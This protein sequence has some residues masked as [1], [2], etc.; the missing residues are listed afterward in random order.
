MEAMNMMKLALV[1]TSMA[2]MTLLPALASAQVAVSVQMPSVQVSVNGPEGEPPGPGYVWEPARMVN[3]NGV[4]VRQPGYWRQVQQPQQVVVQQAP[5]VVVQQ[6]PPV[7]VYEPVYEQAV[8]VEAAPPAPM[9][10]ARPPAPCHDAVW[11][12]GYWGFK[13]RRYSWVPGRWSG[14]RPGYVWQ[15]PQWH[16]QGRGWS[17]QPGFW[18]QASWDGNR[19]RGGWRRDR[20]HDRDRDRDRD[21]HHHGRRGHGRH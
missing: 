1:G 9:V 18:R 5:P 21:R 17:S 15:A 4:W 11:I 10:E 12:A 13:H 3:R 20:D 14:P 19:D 2:A 7:V 16:R 6:A 8:Y